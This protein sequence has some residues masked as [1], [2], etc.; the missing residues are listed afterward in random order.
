MRAV[1]WKHRRRYGARRI[2]EELADLDEVCSPRR[3][4]G[5]L[6]TQGLRAIPAEVVGAQD[7]PQSAPLVL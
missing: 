1:F 5:I 2:A 4:A 3:V 7:D 6:K